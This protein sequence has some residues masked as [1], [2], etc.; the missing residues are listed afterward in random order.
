MARKPKLGQITFRLP[1]ELHAEMLEVAR[2]DEVD[3]S[4][5]LRCII[6]RQ[7]PGYRARVQNRKEEP[8]LKERQ[9][10]QAERKA[11]DE[12]L[13]RTK[14][15]A[16]TAGRDIPNRD[17]RLRTMLLACLNETIPLAECDLVQVVANAEEAL[18]LESDIGAILK[19]LIRDGEVERV[20]DK[21]GQVRCRAARPST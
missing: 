18:C 19:E 20:A 13:A 5:L 15:T 9:V 6:A 4:D 2:L 7:L 21:T 16:M 8:G 12:R 10:E 17:Q 14:A 11:R 3:V 1:A